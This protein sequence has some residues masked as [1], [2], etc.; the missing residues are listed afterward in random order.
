MAQPDRD[1]ISSNE[2][3]E[4]EASSEIKS[5][6]FH[7][8]I[9]AMTGASFNHNLITMNV[10]TTLF[11]PLRDLGCFIFSGDIRIQVQQGNH[12]T[13][14]D[15]SMVCNRVDFEGD[16]NDTILNPV[17]IIE[18]L[19]DSTKNYDRGSK[20]FAYRAIP[21]LK[22]YILIDQYACHVEYFRKNDAEQWV[23]EEL[24]NSDDI[25]VIRSLGI[26]LPL[27]TIYERVNW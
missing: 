12:Y 2:Y 9:F 21:S 19:S 13:Y 18:V 15:I 27:K 4:I 14:P 24:T 5:E 25:L 1:H 16:R 10:S 3:F 17:A 23:L 6:Y 8:S 22:D 11:G 20:F 7:G 26:D